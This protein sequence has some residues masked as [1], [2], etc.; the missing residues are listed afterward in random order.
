MYYSVIIYLS[1]SGKPHTSLFMFVSKMPL[2]Y[3]I[4]SKSKT[5]LPFIQLSLAYMRY[6]TSIL[7]QTIQVFLYSEEDYLH[8]PKFL[9]NLYPNQMRTRTADKKVDHRDM[10]VSGGVYRHDQQ[11]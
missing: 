4:V 3:R 6:G 9:L 10:I 7:L 8:L 5:L 2:F 11:C 1:E